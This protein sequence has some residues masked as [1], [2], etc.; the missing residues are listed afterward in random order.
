MSRALV[1]K[2]D[3]SYVYSI[4]CRWAARQLAAPACL[5]ATSQLDP[6]TQLQR[7][8]CSLQTCDACFCQVTSL[9]RRPLPAHATLA[10]ASATNVQTCSCLL[11]PQTSRAC[12]VHPFKALQQV[13]SGWVEVIVQ[14]QLF[15]G[16]IRN[17]ACPSGHAHWRNRH[18]RWP[19]EH[20][21]RA[22]SPRHS[23]TDAAAG[24]GV[25]LAS[26]RKRRY[27]MCDSTHRRTVGLCT[28]V[29]PPPPTSTTHWA[30][31]LE[32]SRVVAGAALAWRHLCVY[33]NMRAAGMPSFPQHASSDNDHSRSERLAAHRSRIQSQCCL[34]ARDAG[35][36]CC[37]SAAARLLAAQ[38]ALSPVVVPLLRA[39]PEAAAAR[40][41]ASVL[42]STCSACCLRCF[43]CLS[44]PLRW[45][46]GR[47]RSHCDAHLCCSACEQTPG[48][49]RQRLTQP[50]SM[51]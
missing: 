19:S 22:I 2:P 17:I 1:R 20:V 41:V 8:V 46:R 44:R 36:I 30:S 51:A 29:R 26:P 40:D 37:A 33:G 27:L 13:V 6:L 23:H 34:L 31:T 18:H 3:D 28:A 25:T 16:K 5:E 49:S 48:R 12:S 45:R 35:T 24:Y 15:A 42:C 43:V 11:A 9:R 10:N 47:S 7:L 4:A 21:Y 38:T 39:P 50:R 32:C 14:A